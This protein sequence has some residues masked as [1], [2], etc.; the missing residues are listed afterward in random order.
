MKNSVVNKND[1][2]LYLMNVPLTLFGKK[3]RQ[4]IKR[5]LEKVHPCFSEQFSF[6]S[7][8][9]IRKGKIQTLIAVMDKVKVL[10]YKRNKAAGLHLE[11]VKTA[12]L[13]EGK[14][15]TLA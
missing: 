6:D 1:Y 13:F 15:K 2:E 11:G 3:R 7:K 4:F 12:A 9:C 5:E 14:G 10:E 8:R